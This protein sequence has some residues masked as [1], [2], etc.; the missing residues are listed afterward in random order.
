VP[1]AAPRPG[2]C[3]LYG[4]WRSR[5]T[6]CTWAQREPRGQGHVQRCLQACRPIPKGCLARVARSV[7]QAA[8]TSLGDNTCKHEHVHSCV[9]ACQGDPGARLAQVG[10][11]GRGRQPRIGICLQ[12]QRCVTGAQDQ[13]KGCTPERPV[14]RQES[15]RQRQA[16]RSCTKC[17]NFGT[18]GHRYVRSCL[19]ACGGHPQACWA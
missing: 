18:G 6:D 10:R 7:E 1:G 11:C 4:R 13:H 3:V 15:V 19:E 2:K 16:S 14:S 5:R 9:Q 17:T 8:C 12:G